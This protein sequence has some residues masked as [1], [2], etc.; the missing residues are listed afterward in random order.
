MRRGLLLGLALAGLAATANADFVT[1]YADFI[2]TEVEDGVWTASG[3][4]NMALNTARFDAIPLERRAVMEFPLDV[5][6]DNFEV[7]SATLE[8]QISQFT[9]G[10][11]GPDI[12]FNGYAGDGVLEIADAQQSFNYVGQT[13]EIIGLGPL[14]IPLET[15]LLDSLTPSDYYGLWTYQLVDGMQASFD[16]QMGSTPKLVIEYTPEP[17]SL[18]LL[19]VVLGLVRRR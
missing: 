6:P 8:V 2:Q 1:V 17:A 5:L 19:A 18:V 16:G 7:L 12:Q 14:S 13:A 15:A 3:G 11:M 4:A 10:L 9:P